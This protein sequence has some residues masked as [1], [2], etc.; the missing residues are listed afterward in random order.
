MPTPVY[1]YVTRDSPKNSSGYLYFNKEH[2]NIGGMVDF[3]RG[4][5]YPLK[6]GTYFFILSVK[7][8]FHASCCLFSI[9]RNNVIVRE[10]DC[11]KTDSSSRIF[12][13]FK[14][15]LEKGDRIDIFVKVE[16]A[17]TNSNIHHQENESLVHFSGGLL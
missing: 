14:I 17:T 5:F 16:G 4:D 15:Y 12:D 7:I 6:N 13:H 10:I 9:K 3:R 1:F 2:V 11:T 8:T